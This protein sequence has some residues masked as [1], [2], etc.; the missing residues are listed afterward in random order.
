VTVATPKR[1]KSYHRRVISGKSPRKLGLLSPDTEQYESELS[2]FEEMPPKQVNPKAPA[3]SPNVETPVESRN[4]PAAYQPQS[5]SAAV[6]TPPVEA[7]Y[8][9][10]TFTSCDSSA[11]HKII[12]RYSTEFDAAS[13]IEGIKYQGFNRDEFIN[14][15]LTKISPSQLVRLAL[16]GSV[17]GANFEKIAKSSSSIEA[18]IVELISQNVVLRRAKKS[19]DITILRCAAA[20]PQWTAY[21]MGTSGVPKKFG[22][23][24]CPNSL[25]FPAAGALPMSA[26]VRAQHV[27]FAIHFSRVIGGEFNENIYMAMV[28]NMLPLDQIPDELKLV[29]GVSTIEEASQVDVAAIISESLRSR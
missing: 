4:L 26:A 16:L 21:F 28:N 6:A 5:S 23:L 14:A 9:T 8:F 2:L 7:N 18:D 20:I 17:R 24:S 27:Q 19:T 13:F 25:Q 10:S 11:L 1:I 22:S 29:L 3:F 12:K 15:A